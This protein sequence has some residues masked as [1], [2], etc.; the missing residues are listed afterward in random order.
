VL[1]ALAGK[2]A[3]GAWKPSHDKPIIDAA[4]TIAR[5]TAEA[6]LALAK[7]TRAAESKLLRRYVS[8][9]DALDARDH[10]IGTIEVEDICDRFDEL[11]FA[12]A[13]SDDDSLFDTWRDF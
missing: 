3:F 8:R 2:R 7:P 1:R 4:E 11:R 13:L 5:E 9:F 10:F 6:L 12:T